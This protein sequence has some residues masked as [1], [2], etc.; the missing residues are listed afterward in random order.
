MKFS[1]LW[2]VD[3]AMQILASSTADAKL[4]AEAVEWLMLY[5]PPEIQKLLLD[6][7]NMAT[8]KAFP[9]LQPTHVTPD[10]RPVYNVKELAQTLGIREDEVKE[11]LKRKELEH[12]HQRPYPATTRTVH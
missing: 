4:W 11:I 2:D 3:S 12:Q 8:S 9:E 5:G 1:K 7:S 10:G 6:A